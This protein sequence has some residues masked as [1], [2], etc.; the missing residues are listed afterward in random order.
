MEDK[1]QE[2]IKKVN[3]LIKDVQVAMLTTID[4]GVLRSRP[5]QT[6]EAE[7]DGDLWFFTS[8][9]THKT[10]EIEKDR[11][12]NVSYAAPDSNTY[13]SVSGTAALVNDKE[14]IEEL[15]NPILKAWFPKGLDDPTL[16]LLKV[17]VEQAE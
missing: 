5:M 2:S 7:F 9:D 12:V 15:W 8:T 4:W 10:D 3:D 1:R 16:I 14:K 17:S 13:V 6:Q 11:R